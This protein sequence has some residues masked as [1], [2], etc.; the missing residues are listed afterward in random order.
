MFSDFKK[1]HLTKLSLTPFPNLPLQSWVYINRELKDAFETD[2]TESPP[3]VVCEA[4]PTFETK[5]E[6]GPVEQP[7]S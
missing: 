4:G 2:F 3:C 1:I 6:D 7:V 5:T